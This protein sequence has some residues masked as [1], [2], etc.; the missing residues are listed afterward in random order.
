MQAQLAHPDTIEPVRRVGWLLGLG[1]FLLP[2]IF[3]WFT[4][5]RGQTTRARVISFAWLVITLIAYGTAQHGPG[6]D[7][8]MEEWSASRESQVEMTL[9]HRA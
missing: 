9:D 7:P 6:D 4:L 5:R 8:S 3:A 1:I 2:L